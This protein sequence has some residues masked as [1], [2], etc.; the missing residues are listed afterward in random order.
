MVEVNELKD[1][2]TIE[3]LAR[4]YNIPITNFNGSGRCPQCN[5][6]KSL[7]VWNNKIFKCYKCDYKGDIFSLLTRGGLAANFKEALNLVKQTLDISGFYSDYSYRGSTLQQIFNIYK[8]TAANNRQ[9]VQDYFDSR[10]WDMRMLEKYDVGLSI[11]PTT[12][13]DAGIAPAQLDECKLLLKSKVHREYYDNHLIFPVH[14]QSG[15]LVHLNGRALDNRDLR[16]LSTSTRYGGDISKYFYN[17]QALHSNKET[18]E[19]DK[20]NTLFL[21]EGVS[22][23]F[24]LMHLTRCALGQF[25]INVQQAPYHN[26]FSKF[27]QI[28]AIFDNDMYP[29]GDLKAGEYKSWSQVVPNLVDLIS[30][31]KKPI[32]YL[33]VPQSYGIKDL[34]DW[35]LSIDYDPSSFSDYVRRNAKPLTYLCFEIYKDN[36]KLHDYIHRCAAIMPKSRKKWFNYL[37]TTYGS[38]EDYLIMKYEEV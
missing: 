3:M 24:S 26:D 10:G 36:I 33:N 25:G 2:V 9:T 4:K 32:Y 17:S 18:E 31:T 14:N 30:L 29:E 27:D 19:S 12:L 8:E 6:S 15:R 22:D 34:N 35:L 7:K 13:L 21:C 11:K 28:I 5:G 23:C 38:L 16:W 1:L 37:I 20:E